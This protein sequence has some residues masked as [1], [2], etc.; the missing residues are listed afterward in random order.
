MD[1]DLE[2]RRQVCFALY[3]ASRV[4]TALYRPQL[5]RLGLTY[6]QYLVLLVLWEHGSS[7]VKDIG[8][9]L[10]L[11]SGTLSPL[12]KRMEVAGLVRRERSRRDERSVEVHLTPHGDALRT[13]A[14]SLPSTVG[15]AS[16]LSVHELTALR[17]NLVSLTNA[18]SA[19][20]AAQNG[21]AA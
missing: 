10:M 16:G 8:A 19:R 14:A 11:D 13:Q 20:L 4:V 7:T 21:D 12:L 9:E 15:A 5:E 6:P 2:L 3:S 18:V 1:R 17:E